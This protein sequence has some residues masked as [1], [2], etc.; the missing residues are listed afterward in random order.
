M[1]DALQC[2]DYQPIVLQRQQSAQRLDALLCD[3]VADLLRCATGRRIR[4]G[5]G[6]LLFDIEVGRR[7]QL[8]QRR[9]QTTV[10]HF[11]DLVL[12]AGSD[13]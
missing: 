12:V 11:L 1:L 3:Q 7:Q 5:P 6:C 8:H 13:V 4:D 9:D 2:Y 10:D